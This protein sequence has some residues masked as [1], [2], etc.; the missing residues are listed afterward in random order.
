ME[1]IEQYKQLRKIGYGGPGWPEMT[2]GSGCWYRHSKSRRIRLRVAEIREFHARHTNC[3]IIGGRACELGGRYSIEHSKDR[4]LPTGIKSP[5]DWTQV[6][7]EACMQSSLALS[8]RGL[9]DLHTG[10]ESARVGTDLSV[11]G[12]S[13]AALVCSS[14]LTHHSI[15]IVH[16]HDDTQIDIA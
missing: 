10:R 8:S 15:Y 6:G 3:K 16:K 13:L 12:R 9:V 4:H 11:A 14:Q 5:S 7:G 2:R 1:Y